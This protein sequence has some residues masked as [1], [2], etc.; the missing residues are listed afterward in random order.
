MS[1]VMLCHRLLA[2]VKTGCA[3][4]TARDIYLLC[5][6]V[7]II[8]GK[9]RLPGKSAEGGLGKESPRLHVRQ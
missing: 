6:S 9:E 1:C 4:T 8:S 7:L 2:L 5:A 3:G